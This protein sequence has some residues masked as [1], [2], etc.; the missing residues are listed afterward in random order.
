MNVK[1]VWLV[2]ETLLRKIQAAAE[3]VAMSGIRS[4]FPK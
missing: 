2:G 4:W 1:K 3:K